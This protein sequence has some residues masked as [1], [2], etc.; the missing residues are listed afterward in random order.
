MGYNILT[1]Q[2][3]ITHNTSFSYDFGV[4]NRFMKSVS[5]SEVNLS[6]SSIWL[7]IYEIPNVVNWEQMFAWL[8][9]QACVLVQWYFMVSASCG[10]VNLHKSKTAASNQ[11]WVSTYW[12]INMQWCATPIFHGNLIC[13][14]DLWSISL[15]LVSI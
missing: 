3:R 15:F 4:P 12:S 9:I 7:R 11:R 6:L 13:Q 5:W 10:S 1:N 14:F 8:V 2:R